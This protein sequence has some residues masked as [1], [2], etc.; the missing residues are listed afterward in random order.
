MA[1]FALVHGAWHGAWC[2]ERLSPELERLGHRVVTMD[3]PCD[4]PG[5]AFGTYADVVC[6]ALDDV[7]DQPV[8]VG[9]SLAGHT[10]PL[11]AA[12][13]PVRRLVFLCA[14]L[15][16]PG[17][18]FAQQIQEDPSM[19]FRGEYEPGLAPPD[20]GGCRRWQDFEIARR[21][22][23]AD[24]TDADVRWAFERLRAQSATPY[25]QPA[26]TD[27]LPEVERTYICCSEDRI[28]N[29]EWARCAAVERLGVEPVD[30]PGSHSPFLSR[31]AV[32]AELLAEDL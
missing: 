26:P 28:V 31:P 19:L 3:L 6:A 17:V 10:I 8:V 25:L 4:D 5:A 29:P 13:R 15:P 27:A 11:V 20:D 12:R 2:W 23:Y 30:L 1:T 21:T 7:R 32:L 9:H 22:F 16:L 18:S 14:L 24:C